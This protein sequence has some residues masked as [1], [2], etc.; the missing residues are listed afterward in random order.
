M[1]LI[2]VFLVLAAALSL[3]ACGQGA[4]VRPACPAAKVCLEV[5]NGADPVSLDPNKIAG[6]QEDRI[7]SD[8]MVGLVQSDPEGRPVPGMATSWDASPDGKV[9]TFHLR[10]AKW[11]DGM[12]VTADD[13]VF[14]M[15]R[16]V[17][18]A[19]GS[20]Y[21]SLMFIIQ[22]AEAINSGK[23]PPSALGVR[24][25]DPRTLEI[26]L[27]HPAPYLP[28]L[29]K[30]QTMYPIPRHAVEKWGD[31]WT[32]PSHYV[33]NGPFKLVDWR[34][35]DH[36][37]AV[38]NPL[39]WDAPSVCVDQVD[40][41]PTTDSVAAER[42]VRRGELDAND[43]IDA[44]RVAFVRRPDQI[45]QYAHVHTYLGVSYL[46][47]NTKDMRAFR[48]RRVRIALAMSIDRDFIADKLL[49]GVNKAAYTFVPPGVANYVSPPPPVWASWPLARRQAAARVLL[50]QA[51]Y[52]PGH[53]LAVE[54]KQS[55]SNTYQV[56]MPSIQS[57][58]RAIGVTATLIQEEAQIAFEDY[59]YRNF[60]V[61]TAAW[62]ADYNDAMSFLYLQQS[63]TGAQNYGDYA[64][65]VFD[66]LLAQADNEPDIKKRAADLERAEAI[67]LRDAPITPLVYAVNTNLVNPR[68]T[69]FVDNIVDQHRTRYLCVKG[70]GPR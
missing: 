13:F 64:N 47:F 48:D 69:G 46:A 26:R 62:I 9:W 52:G 31:A 11:S 19:T 22:N 50:A 53:S 63:T 56:I 68:V 43:H 66:G 70:A 29:A 18:P 36:I 32:Q 6:T 3:G 34:L 37:R 38:K 65:P 60:Q 42:R 28:E 51:G 2:P 49:R 57:D 39:F 20:Q 55:N 44:N 61:A 45:P 58:W 12:P 14:G 4:P 59:R 35:G 17:T 67:M 41:Y 10:D 5:G 24:A 27:V 21:A 40:Y 1:R 30:H 16:L 8:L 15:R 23:L 33:G 25:I 54:I 7:V